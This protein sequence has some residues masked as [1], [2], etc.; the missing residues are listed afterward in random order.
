MSAPGRAERPFYDISY[1]NSRQASCLTHVT[2]RL[3]YETWVSS[4]MNAYVCKVR[5]QHSGKEARLHFAACSAFVRRQPDVYSNVLHRIYCRAI[6][7]F[8][9]ANV[10]HAA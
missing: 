2:Q 9:H 8:S 7:R 5:P 6:L 4:A 3:E 10:R 1:S